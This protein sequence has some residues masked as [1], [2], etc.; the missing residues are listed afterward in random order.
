MLKARI[1]KAKRTI[2]SS[3]D[4]EKPKESKGLF[5]F[6]ATAAG[7][8]FPV[9][10][11]KGDAKQSPFQATSL[12]GEKA[13]FKFDSKPSSGLQFGGLFGNA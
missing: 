1:I 5:Q 8:L 3:A 10:E 7:S 12:F 2:T 13:T 11:S 6:S 9:T 4:G